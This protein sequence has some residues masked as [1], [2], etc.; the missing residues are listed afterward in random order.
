[1]SDTGAEAVASHPRARLPRVRLATVA[2]VAAGFLA[3]ATVTI[4]AGVGRVDQWILGDWLIDYSAGFTRRGLLGEA[5][6]QLSETTGADRIVTT[7]ALQLAALAALAAALL[8]LVWNHDRGLTTVLLVGSPAFVLFLMN[9]LGTMRKEI[10]LW[11]LVAGVLAWSKTRSAQ[12]GRIIPWLLALGFPVLVM[13]HEALAFYAGFIAVVLWL[14]VADKVVEKRQASVAG[15]VGG[16]L[17]GVAL[18][19]SAL[20]QGSKQVGSGICDTLGQAGYSEALCSGAIGF[21]DRDA[22]AAIARVGNEIADGGHLL[23]YFVVV[24]LA[25]LPFVFVRASKALLA[26]VVVSL[27]ATVPLFV[28]SIDWGRWI[29]ISVWL[30][31]L[32]VLRFDGTDHL[33]VKPLRP[34]TG[35]SLFA[36]VALAA[37]Y[38]T[39][40]SVPHCCEPRVGFGLIDRIAD[41]GRFFVG[42]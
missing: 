13:V 26:A 36:G 19:V 41:V 6:R 7:T 35:A 1:V 18:A 21:L 24:V 9:P 32:V 25:A 27:V 37:S 33:T 28:V 14:L 8:V 38:V 30:V 23:T 12:A 4:R 34:T 5:I 17:A 15:V 20:W 2:I 29:V 39:L 40:W 22:S 31:T 42:G 16:V 3:A 11:L 10:L